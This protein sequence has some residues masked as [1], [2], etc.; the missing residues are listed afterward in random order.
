MANDLGIWDPLLPHAAASLF[1][2]VPFPW[3]IAGG[4]AI[5]LFVG[6]QTRPHDDLDVLVLRR[7][8]LAV[9]AA[10]VGWDL[11][12]AD[13]PGTLRPWRSGEIL[14]QL[15]HDIWCRPTPASPWALQLMVADHDG[16]RWLYRRDP[17]VGRPISE[18]GRRS[19]EGYPYLAPEVQLLFKASPNR[20]P[21]DEHDFATAL[22][23]L[24]VGSRGWLASALDTWR[25]GH[26]WLAQLERV[27][28]WPGPC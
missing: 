21:K 2:P 5:D 17:R 16:E 10:L 26:P 3:W 6:Q 15:I 22:P 18:L 20:R 8:L 4:W 24:D 19:A 28:N 25:P 27:A 23:L 13:P 9:Q 7:D 14:A 11:H 1:H 12:A